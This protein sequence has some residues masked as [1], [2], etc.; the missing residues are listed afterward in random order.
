M[1]KITYCFLLVFLLLGTTPIVSANSDIPANEP[2]LFQKE[3]I[4]KHS[5]NNN[6]KVLILNSNVRLTEVVIY[7]IIGQQTFKQQLNGLRLRVQLSDLKK[8]VY[9]AKL[10]GANF[11]KTIRLV[12]K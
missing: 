8:G 9:I 2:T 4:V 3:A 5:F 7:N 1:Q 6:S 10:K 12:I 11:T